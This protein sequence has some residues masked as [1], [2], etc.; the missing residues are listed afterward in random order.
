MSEW[1]GRSLV[2]VRGERRVFA[3]L[4]FA[5]ARDGALVLVGPNGSGKSSLLRMMA[6]L[7]PPA[8]GALLW[9]GERIDRDPDA[10]RRR[11][12]Y[13]GH[14][15][16]VKP[17]LSVFENLETWSRLWGGRHGADERTADALDA[18]GIWRLA[19]IPGRFLSAG[20]RRRLALARLLAAPAVL[21]LLDEPRTGLDDESAARLDGIIADHRADGGM[22]VMALHGGAHPP[23]AILL[24]LA[25]AADAAAWET[26]DGKCETEGATAPW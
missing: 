5:L 2:C 25:E 23:G 1:E 16:A 22:V 11:V 10:H 13:V 9:D 3:G 6:G 17:A 15:D 14:A 21:W 7:L 20:Q 24:S 4:S 26:P 12:R 8:A 19:D 18:L